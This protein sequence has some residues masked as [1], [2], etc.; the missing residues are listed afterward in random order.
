[1]NLIKIEI[2]LNS[3]FFLLSLLNKWKKKH[4]L[5][6]VQTFTYILLTISKINLS[7]KGM[8]NYPSIWYNSS[9]KIEIGGAYLETPF[10]LQ[11]SCVIFI[12]FVFD[13]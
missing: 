4:T 7:T 2:C 1:M 5:T 13:Q 10:I 11:N 9:F 8:N 3:L 6:S 12:F